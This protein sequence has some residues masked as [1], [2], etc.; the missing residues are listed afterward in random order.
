MLS[1]NPRKN[2][3]FFEFIRL[4]F[5]VYVEYFLKPFKEII[6]YRRTYRN[7][8]EVIKMKKSNQYPIKAILRNGTKVN[9]NNLFQVRMHKWRLKENCEFDDEF[10]IIHKDGFPP[11][12]LFD[13]E[14]NGDLGDVFFEDEYKFLPVKG[15]QVVD[16]G[17][18][19]GDSSIYF[20]LKGAEKVIALEPS[21]KNFESAKINIKLNNLGEKINLIQAGCSS[22]KGTTK[23]NKDEGGA[24]YSLQHNDSSSVSVPVITLHDI[25]Q[26]VDGKE[27]VLKM[28]CE[29][30]EYETI[31]SSSKE[32][33]QKFSHIQ[34]EYH[35]GYKNLKIKLEECGFKVT[36]THPW[37]GR[38]IHSTMSASYVGFLFAQKISL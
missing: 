15:K 6:V 12:K 13:W 24:R 8:V 3:S 1:Y 17:A 7:F 36:K 18:N 23:V 10:L 35:Y 32:T 26:L 11:I 30:C 19:I 4:H 33:L 25:L 14:E 29:G 16:I 20:A 31:L 5:S 28:D 9:L 38:Q 2:M 22:K 21:P 27:C 37:R 34:V